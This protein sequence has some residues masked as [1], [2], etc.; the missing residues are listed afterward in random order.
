MC[1]RVVATTFSAVCSVRA[2][3]GPLCL[4]LPR[5]LLQF[6]RC[7]S[8]MP[9]RLHETRKSEVRVVD[10]NT[11]FYFCCC[12]CWC[13][14]SVPGN[15]LVVAF[16]VVSAR[17]G[18]SAARLRMWARIRHAAFL[19]RES[20]SRGTCERNRRYGRLSN[21]EIRQSTADFDFHC[22]TG[23]IEDARLRD[24]RCQ[25]VRRPHISSGRVISAL[26]SASGTIV[27]ATYS[28]RTDSTVLCIPTSQGVF[29]RRKVKVVDLSP[30]RRLPQ[31]CVDRWASDRRD[32]SRQSLRSILDDAR[33]AIAPRSLGF[34]TDYEAP[35]RPL[36]ASSSGRRRLPT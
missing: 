6:R 8:S 34:R 35:S 20:G 14:S 19:R 16:W 10:D 25:S 13:G 17:V 7:V 2:V 5:G 4:W 15:V 23:T 31:Q 21:R 28:F 9:R 30:R 29:G 32:G 3:S 27:S 24:V 1:I 18:H 36:A 22:H 26:S 12:C 33:V 11:Y